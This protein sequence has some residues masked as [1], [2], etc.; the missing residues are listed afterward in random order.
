MEE[1]KKIKEGDYFRSYSG[2]VGQ[3]LDIVCMIDGR[4]YIGFKNNN[5]KYCLL[6]IGDIEKYSSNII[7]LFEYE[8]VLKV[9]NKL[10]N[11]Y[12]YYGFSENNFSTITD[13]KKRI[14]C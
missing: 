6:D 9:Y 10:Y 2:L 1:I 5:N 4:P 8:D 14:A 11:G 12:M 7:D 13:L 3:V